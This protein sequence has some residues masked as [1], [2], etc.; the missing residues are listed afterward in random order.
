M[1]IFL[2][3]QPTM[4]FNAIP[5]VYSTCAGVARETIG[6]LLL[7]SGEQV[8][9][10]DS[11]GLSQEEG[12]LVGDASDACLYL[13]QGSPGD[14]QTYPLAFGREL[15]LGKALLISKPADLFSYDVR[16]QVLLHF[17][18]LTLEH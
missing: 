13:G 10:G 11:Q 17:W 12:F 6:L 14:V 2:I 5:A 4:F 8:G 18:N 1:R 3:C 9:D 7:A 15:V 16:G